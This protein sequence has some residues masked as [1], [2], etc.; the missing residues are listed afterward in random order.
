M[1]KRLASLPRKKAKKRATVA[2]VKARKI[3]R[4]LKKRSVRQPK[5]DEALTLAAEDVFLIYDAAESAHGKSKA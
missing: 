1:I 2:K 3:T 4:P 5:T